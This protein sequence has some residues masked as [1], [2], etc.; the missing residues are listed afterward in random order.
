[1]DGLRGYD[2]MLGAD[3]DQRA[4]KHWQAVSHGKGVGYESCVISV[5]GYAPLV[6]TIC[7]RAS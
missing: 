1:M 2:A 6:L 5:G 3:L 4:E 7:A